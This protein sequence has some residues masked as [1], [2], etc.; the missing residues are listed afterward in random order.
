MMWDTPE[1]VIEQQLSPGERLLWSGQPR[2]GFQLCMADAFLIPFSLLWCGFAVFWEV[3]AFN[4]GAPLFFMLFGAPIVVIGLHLVFGRFFVDI[5]MRH[6]TFY[7]VTNERIIIVAGLFSRQTQSLQLQTLSN[8]L[9]TE[10]ADGSGTIVFNP[11]P[12]LPLILQRPP[13]GFPGAGRYAPPGFDR[14]ENVKEVYD[15][16][17]KTQKTAE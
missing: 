8:T 9:L 17:R 11:M 1:S 4:M 14:I 12:Q 10:R 6:R 2:G 3:T 15:L 16:I 7:G 5:W 13:A